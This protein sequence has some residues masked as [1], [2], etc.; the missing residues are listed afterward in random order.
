MATV[1]DAVALGMQ[2]EPAKIIAGLVARFDSLDPEP[3]AAEK[4][5][6]TT[7]MMALGLPRQLAHLIATDAGVPALM[8]AGLPSALAVVVD[9]LRDAG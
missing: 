2:A 1:N 3:L 7:D 8:A 6:A 5:E 9:A 4:L